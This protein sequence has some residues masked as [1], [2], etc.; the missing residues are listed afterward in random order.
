MSPAAPPADLS[1]LAAGRS[2]EFSPRPLVM[3]RNG[4]VSCG[5][6]LA[7]TAARHVFDL[8][9]NASDAGV[10]AG[11]CL[12]VL[13]PHLTSFA[14]VAP[15][16]I[17]DPDLARRDPASRGVVT[18]SGLGR[19]PKAASLEY[20]H[21]HHNGKLPEG[22]LRWVT[23]AAADAWLLAL[24]EFGTLSLGEVVEPALDLATRGF[25]VYENL[26]L[27]L[28]AVRDKLVELWPTTAE[29]F[30]PEGRVP[31][32]GALLPQ[33][34]LATVFRAMMDAEARAR[35][36]G[37][38]RREALEAARDVFY[39]GWVAQAF[40]DFARERG[41]LITYDDIAASR[42]RLEPPVSVN[43]RGVDVYACGFWCQGPVLL[44]CLNLLEPFDLVALGHNS[45]AYLHLLAEV[46]KLAF[47]DREAYYGDPDFVEVPAAGLLSKAYAA[48]QARRIDPDRAVPRLPDPG[49]PWAFEPG[50]DPA[51][52]PRLVDVERYLASAPEP[53][54]DTS[55][56]ATMDAE[57]RIFSATPSDPVIEGPVCPATGLSL[58]FRGVQS[59]LDPDHPSAVA[60]GKRPRLT[61][62]PA[63]ALAGGEPLCGFGCPGGDTQTQ[64]ML[65]VFLNMVDHGMNPQQAINAPRIA[66]WS[67]PDSFYPH[68]YFPGR[69]WVERSI[70]E[71]I[72]RGLKARGHD[73]TVSPQPYG[74]TSMMHVVA[75]APGS[76]T[77]L[78]AADIRGEAYA[79]A[80]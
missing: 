42:V 63:L 73:V 2:G 45:E 46:L 54:G 23:P 11:V 79:Q 78:A 69:L 49:N 60:P 47:A 76:R 67:F 56:V 77:L 1:R 39:R 26:H 74:G 36:E 20:F 66:S 37:R 13:T 4:V 16:I 50:A 53:A 6:N 52:G 80:W 15:I 51:L 29:V 31:E 62:N 64:G 27:R 17:R 8:G 55:Y 33:P 24:A 5:H 41:A 21:R 72:R 28:A 18:V 43:Y 65:Q 61:P 58:S 7:A 22:V 10:A 75:K 9:G 70:P 68:P 30:V 57:G 44:Q 35:R 12:N 48:A 71:E 59:R 19:W 40:G 14:G 38:D 34:A 3:G 32:I 25:P